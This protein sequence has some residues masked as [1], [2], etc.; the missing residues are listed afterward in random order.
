MRY[1][2]HLALTGDDSSEIKLL[3]IFLHFNDLSWFSQ[4]PAM[5]FD[6][7]CDIIL[8]N[9]ETI[10][11]RSKGVDNIADTP[12]TR[13]HSVTGKVALAFCTAPRRQFANYSILSLG[14][15]GRDLPQFCGIYPFEVMAWIFSIDPMNPYAPLPIDCSWEAFFFNFPF[16]VMAR[17]F[18]I[19]PENPYA[20]L[21]IECRW[22]AFYLNHITPMD[23]SLEQKHFRRIWKLVSSKKTVNVAPCR[24]PVE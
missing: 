19:N 15:S 20:P 6:E 1:F 22:E 11:K 13:L 7:V 14:P 3:P 18:S 21:L 5:I 16:E 9:L 2:F 23:S 8:E 4:N 12:L 17:I 10:E 24:C